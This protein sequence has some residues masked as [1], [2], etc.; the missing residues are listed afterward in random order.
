M[1]LLTCSYLDAAKM[2]FAPVVAEAFFAKC[3][4]VVKICINNRETSH[5]GS[6]LALKLKSAKSVTVNEGTESR[7]LTELTDDSFGLDRE[8]KAI[9]ER[10]K[11]R[12]EVIGSLFGRPKG[13]WQKSREYH[14][15]EDQSSPTV[16]TLVLRMPLM[17]SKT[18]ING[19]AKDFI[20]N[21]QAIDIRRSSAI[22]KHFNSLLLG[23][24][25]CS[26]RL[27]RHFSDQELLLQ[28]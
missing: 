15:T 18:T 11:E 26:E 28:G 2:A 3:V 17:G 1:L 10:F 19:V 12:L 4:Q 20:C 23:R 8:V 13:F 7:W 6:I 27:F 14:A 5:V 21:Y 25:E 22:W 9:R 24:R 16:P